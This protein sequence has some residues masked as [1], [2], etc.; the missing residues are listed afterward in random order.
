MSGNS[1]CDISNMHICPTCGRES[2][3]MYISKTYINDKP[4]LEIKFTH[5]GEVCECIDESGGYL[6]FIP[7]GIDID[8]ISQNWY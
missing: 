2:R 4:Y 6:V 3:I 8:E 5:D 1:I 7:L